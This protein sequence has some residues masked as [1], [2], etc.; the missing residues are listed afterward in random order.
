MRPIRGET[1]GLGGKVV[2]SEV[3]YLRPKLLSTSPE[4]LS[5]QVLTI[6]ESYSFEIYAFRSQMVKVLL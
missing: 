1:V 4:E 6:M 2:G 5:V 3:G